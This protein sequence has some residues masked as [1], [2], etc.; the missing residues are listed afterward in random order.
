MRRPEFHTAFSFHV[1]LMVTERKNKYKEEW[2][3]HYFCS[4]KVFT[5]DS[6]LSSVL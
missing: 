4:S 6:S 2:C 1:L 5:V 3:N